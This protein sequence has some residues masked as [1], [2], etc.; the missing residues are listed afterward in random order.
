[1]EC[2]QTASTLM[3]R[4]KTASARACAPRGIDLPPLFAC[5]PVGAGKSPSGLLLWADIVKTPFSERGR[6][7][8][9]ALSSG[10][11]EVKACHRERLSPRQ[12]KKGAKNRPFLV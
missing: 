7:D 4:R 11:F 2:S 3:A 6:E 8:S 10:F 5:A 1:M 12:R 9:A